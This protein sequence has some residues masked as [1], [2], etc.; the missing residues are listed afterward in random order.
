MECSV[1]REALSAW[2]DGEAVDVD[3]AVVHEHVGGCA[4]CR[5]FE[6]RLAALTALTAAPAAAPSAVPDLAPAVVTRLRRRRES[7]L[8]ILR[9]AVGLMGGAELGNALLELILHGTTEAHATHESLSFAIAISLALV[10]A[11]LRPH[12][13][14]GYVPVVG[15][16]AALLMATATFDVVKGRIAAVD[17]LPHVDL[18]VGLVML[19]LIARERPEPP[20]R[21]TRSWRPPTYGVP[22]LVPRSGGLARVSLVRP[23]AR[24]IRIGLGTLIAGAVVMIPS[25]ASA[26]AILDSST[27]A[28]N[29]VLTTAP[30]TVE[31]TFSESVTPPPGA[32]RVFAPDGSRADNGDVKAD[33]PHVSVSLDA[34]ASGTYLVSWRV[35]SADSHPVSGAYTYSVGHASAAPTAPKAVGSRGFKVA[36]GVS[37]FV[38]YAGGALLV[39]GIAFWLLGGGPSRAGRRLALGGAAGVLVAGIVDIALK[40]PLDAG[41]GLSSISNG[42][43]LQEV[44]GTT[45]GRAE[46]TR[47]LIAVILA[48]LVLAKDRLRIAEWGAV[49]GIFAVLVALT[50]ALAGHAAAGDARPISVPSW[51]LHAL[52]MMVWLG[53][54]AQLV[55]DRVWRQPDAREVLRR[56]SLVALVS[57][58]VLVVTGL[59]QAWRQV[60][61]LG[62]LADTT[63]G[64]LLSVKVGLVVVIVAIAYASRRSLRTSTTRSALGRTVLLEVVA[65]VAVLGVTSGLVATEPAATAYRPT[66]AKNLTIEGDTVQ[67]SAVPAASRQMELHLYVFDKDGQPADPV[68]LTA[69]V[70]LPSRDVGPLPVTL[71]HVDV[72]HSTGLVSVP[73][74][75]D[76]TLAVTV[77]VNDF[78]EATRTVTLPIH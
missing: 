72:G 50:F 13:A 29:A 57:V 4:D 48:V 73:V 76:W 1:A 6:A 33:G 24:P 30:T 39:G 17:E 38:G 42:A 59:F 60:R 47:V 45:Y 36:L 12:L 9:W 52:S 71:Q 35:V 20:A 44:L 62:A 32:L 16:A 43:L 66:V 37:R 63:Y 14:G 26:H 61:S 25:A 8:Y 2:A 27:P 28:P 23:A 34:S 11:A 40:G 5:A 18:L 3:P 78:D 15:T 70:T 67:V 74:V 49:C 46:L 69:T 58:G 10:V 31:L 68:E 21:T 77:R 41:L 51:T 64:H 53:G 55:V 65:L 56:F 54:L 22:R 19:W 7:R 75:G